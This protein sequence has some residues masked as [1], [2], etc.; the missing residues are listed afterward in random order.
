MVRDDLLPRVEEFKHLGFLLMGE[1]RM[2]ERA[3]R[4]FGARAIL[5]CFTKR[6]QHESKALNLKLDLHS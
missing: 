6:A 1:R 3:D 4:Q 5:L 2:E